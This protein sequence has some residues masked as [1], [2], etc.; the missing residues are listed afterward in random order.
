[1][2]HVLPAS[3]IFKVF[4]LPPHTS[5]HMSFKIKKPSHA[6]RFLPS[7]VTAFQSVLFVLA[8]VGAYYM[9]LVEEDMQGLRRQGYLPTR[10]PWHLPSPASIF[11]I[12]GTSSHHVEPATPEVSVTSD[13]TPV[14]TTV[15]V[16]TTRRLPTQTYAAPDDLWGEWESTTADPFSPEATAG[17]TSE[18]DAETSSTIFTIWPFIKPLAG[19]GLGDGEHQKKALHGAKR[20]VHQVSNSVL[21]ILNFTM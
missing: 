19:L 5:H 18:S 15:T 8:L 20:L 14:T 9:T 12:A 7:F 2:A 11:P 21:T 10:Q 16:T 13:P 17:S 6:A 4:S 3:N 1:M